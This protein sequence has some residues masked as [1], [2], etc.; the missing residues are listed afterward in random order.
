MVSNKNT[1]GLQT[2]REWLEANPDSVFHASAGLPSSHFMDWA[3]VTHAKAG[4]ATG[5]AEAIYKNMMLNSNQCEA[6]L[7][8]NAAD[9]WGHEFLATCLKPDKSDFECILIA[10]MTKGGDEPQVEVHYE[11]VEEDDEK[12]PSLFTAPDKLLN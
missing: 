10:Q 7:N 8:N 9:M 6:V 12:F 5:M 11:V 4:D 3:V 1:E 2:L